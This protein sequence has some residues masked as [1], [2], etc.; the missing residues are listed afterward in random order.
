[1]AKPCSHKAKYHRSV[2][3]KQVKDQVTTPPEPGITG[4]N[5]LVARHTSTLLHCV[6][7]SEY[8]KHN[9]LTPVAHFFKGNV[10]RRYLRNVRL[11]WLLG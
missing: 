2:K 8:T 10:G 7:K 9:M 11:S 5:A 3:L 6:S 4:E 1:M